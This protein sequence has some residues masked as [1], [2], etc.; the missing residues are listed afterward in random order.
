MRAK[1]QSLVTETFAAWSCQV[2]VEF[3]HPTV[4]TQPI[5]SDIKKTLASY[6]ATY[7][8]FR[9]SSLISRLSDGETVTVDDAF[10]KL[11]TRAQNLQ[12]QTNGIFSPFIDVS[13]L[14]YRKSFEQQRFFPAQ[15]NLSGVPNSSE[16]ISITA[17]QARLAADTTLDFG[18][19]LKGYVSQVLADKYADVAQGV[20]INLGGDL[21]VRGRDLETRDFVIAIYNPITKQDHQVFLHNQTLC[22][23]GTYKR[24]WHDSTR[25]YHHIVDPRTGDSS[26]SDFVSISFWGDDGALCD[27]LSTAAFSAPVSD[28]DQWCQTYNVAYLA[29]QKDGISFTSLT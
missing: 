17:D 9:A 3:I 5:L 20:I 19:F 15:K 13:A 8:R 12:T 11:L 23:S 10:L 28:W 21:T 1:T 4:D 16:K 18:G 25:T 29:I 27:G 2:A 14:G 7:S 26:Q 6:E 22:T 24:T